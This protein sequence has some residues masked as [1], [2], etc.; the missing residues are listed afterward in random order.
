MKY[1]E[2]VPVKVNEKLKK[3]ENKIGYV[4]MASEGHAVCLD[5][6]EIDLL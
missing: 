6:D 5:N 2:K 3:T 4:D 1:Y